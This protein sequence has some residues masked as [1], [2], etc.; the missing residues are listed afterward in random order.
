ML[1]FIVLAIVAV[2]MPIDAFREALDGGPH[3]TVAL[4]EL[5][6][7]ILTLFADAVSTWVALLAVRMRRPLGAVL[8]VRGASFVL[9]LV[10]YALGQSAFGYYLRRSGASTARAVGATL[11]LMGTN[12]A[13]LLVVTTVAWLAQGASMATNLGTILIVGTGG[14]ALYLVV[15]AARPAVLAKREVLAPLFDAGLGGHALTMLGRLPHL[16]VTVIGVWAAMR[17]WGIPAPFVAA[18]TAMPFVVLVQAIPLAPAGLGTTQ[19]ALV[20]FFSAYA[21]GA[22]ADERSA[23]VFAFAV[24]HFVYYVAASLIVGLACTPFARRSGNLVT[25]ATA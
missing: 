16:V 24:V 20:Y 11:F 6:V 12:L 18:M 15:I 25:S 9:F 17:V 8:S 19:A 2:R 14:F 22:T 13:T 7:A 23:H 4:V 3:G 5:G 1:G 10:N 21:A